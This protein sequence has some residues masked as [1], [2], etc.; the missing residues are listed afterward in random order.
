MPAA[1]LAFVI[2]VALG[3]TSSVPALGPLA[4]AIASAALRNEQRRALAL[5]LSGAVA[6]S[7]WAAVAMLGIGQLVLAHPGS[8]AAL[9]AFGALAIVG[10][11][12]SLFRGAASMR[13]SHPAPA[14]S[15]KSA[16][17]IGFVMVAANPGF[18]LT[19]TGLTSL[20]IGS[21][22]VPY[23]PRWA[24]VLGAFV[25]IVAWFV[26]LFRLVL[27]F[28]TRLTTRWLERAIRSLAALVIACGVALAIS[29]A[30]R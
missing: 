2:G 1:V 14:P 24:V 25:G 22:G 29:A 8:L 5:A 17:V 11:G 16:F 27:R 12:I 19:W 21:D 28:R 10:F 3:F 15:G 30:R 23:S 9:Q 26:A 6:E 13:S 7:M 20:L 18:L 4:L